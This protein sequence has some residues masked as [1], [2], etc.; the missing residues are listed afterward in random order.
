MD[1]Q[2]TF[3]EWRDA[4]DRDD[5][6]EALELAGAYELWLATGGFPA[7]DPD[8]GNDIVELDTEEVRW[9]VAVN[10]LEEWRD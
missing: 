7:K 6:D 3:N 8:D 1:P 10:G 5:I 4:L 9:L 2:A